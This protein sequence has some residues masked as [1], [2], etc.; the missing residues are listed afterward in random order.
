MPTPSP[1]THQ[2][3]HLCPGFISYQASPRTLANEIDWH[4]ERTAPDHGAGIHSKSLEGTETTAS[5]E[6]DA[7]SDAAYD[8]HSV[9][10]ESPEQSV[11]ITGKARMSSLL[12]FRKRR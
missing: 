3:P 1:H 10:N 5:P 4:R 2:V 12:K 6:K 11:V 8:D 9:H 7:V